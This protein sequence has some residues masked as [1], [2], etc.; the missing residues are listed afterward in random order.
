[1]SLHRKANRGWT[2]L[3]KLASR[4]T[5]DMPALHRAGALVYSSIMRA[6]VFLPPPRVLLNTPP[7]SGTHLLGECLSLMPKMMFSGRH[8][9]LANSIE[10]S[11]EEPIYW[12]AGQHPE[13]DE[14]RLNGLLG[15]CPQGMFVT[16]HAGFHPDF[17]RILED[18][19][20]KQIVL[21]RDPRDVAVSHTFYVKR[22]GGHQ[23]HKH[24]VET[25]KSDEERILTDITGIDRN[26]V[27]LPSLSIRELFEGFIPWLEDPS[28]LVVRFEDLVG[29]L[30]GGDGEKQLAQIQ[31]I[32]D[33][34]ERPLTQ[35]QA[36][37]IAEKVFVKSSV[38]FRKGQIGDWQNHF[39]EAHRRAFKEAAGEILIKLGY[40]KDSDW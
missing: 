2:S 33:F 3:L 38:T 35:D 8:F 17:K 1:M 29:P 31:R 16:A 14:S 10:S 18:L 20:F 24:Y 27:D 12:V 40:E 7:K 39:T 28:T 26:A 22:W 9:A 6:N 19:D 30:G 34:V 21:L 4:K 5:M 11:R 36:R 13:L 37:R 32:G 23:F 15:K 25:L